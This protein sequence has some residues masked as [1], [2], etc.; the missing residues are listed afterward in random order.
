VLSEVVP[1]LLSLELPV[2]TGIL[3][4]GTET[5]GKDGSETLFGTRLASPARL[6]FTKTVMFPIVI[7]STLIS[8][9]DTVTLPTV[10]DN[11]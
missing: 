11:C 9:A 6:T 1:E 7:S 5:L 3:T 8:P 10:H 2:S 4:G